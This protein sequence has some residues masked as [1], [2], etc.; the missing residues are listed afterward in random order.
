MTRLDDTPLRVRARGAESHLSEKLKVL[1]A[2]WLH[3]PI[4]IVDLA[5]PLAKPRRRLSGECPGGGS[6]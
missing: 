2:G 4:D 3:C 6:G 1:V 5:M